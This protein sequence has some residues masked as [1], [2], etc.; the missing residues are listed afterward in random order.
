MEE[1]YIIRLINMG[2]TFRTDSGE[3]VALDDINLDIRE[4]AV[5]GIIG[6]SGAGKSTLVRCIN[7]LEIPTS[8]KVLFEGRSLGEMS[9][10][11][12]RE[13]RRR[14]GMIFQQFNLLEQR[15]LIFPKN[16]FL[17]YSF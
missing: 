15:N 11:E 16:D 2:K 13:A 10:K 14:M 8:G 6:L 7:Y 17:L 3:L 5:Q 1:G 4:G 12:V 9:R